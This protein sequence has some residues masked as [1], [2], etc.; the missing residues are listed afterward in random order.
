M[1]NSKDEHLHFYL[2]YIEGFSII[3]WTL[4]CCQLFTKFNINFVKLVQFWCQ[5]LW[6][7]LPQSSKKLF[8][9]RHINLRLCFKLLCD[10]KN[11]HCRSNFSEW[12]LPVGNCRVPQD[13]WHAYATHSSVLYIQHHFHASSIPSPLNVK[14]D[15]YDPWIQLETKTYQSPY[16]FSCT[17]ELWVGGAWDPLRVTLLQGPS[18]AFLVLLA[19]L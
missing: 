16:L 3:H 19:C 5:E 18:A 14:H 4:L 6:H 17:M 13:K 8:R 15:K 9:R 12:Q 2:S 10:T 11:V 1:Q 7:L